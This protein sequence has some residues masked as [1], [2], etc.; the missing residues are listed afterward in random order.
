MMDDFYFSVNIDENRTLCL[1]PITDRLIAM[2]GQ[3][4]EDRGGYYL[5]EQEGR[6]DF[7]RVEILAH[8]IS[9]DGVEKIRDKFNMS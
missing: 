2:A 7:A 8:V 1:S 4:I 9:A 3:E 6:G 5:Y